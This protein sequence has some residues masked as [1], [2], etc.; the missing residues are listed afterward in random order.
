LKQLTQGGK[1][2]ESLMVGS[3]FG[4]HISSSVVEGIGDKL[5]Y[6]LKQ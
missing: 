2:P 6:Y 4:S 5:V 1:S 3:G